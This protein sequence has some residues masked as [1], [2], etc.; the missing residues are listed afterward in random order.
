MI[1]A[2]NVVC[3]D[4]KKNSKIDKSLKR[5]MR[6]ENV[7]GAL[8]CGILRHVSV[9]SD[10]ILGNNYT[11]SYRSN[12]LEAVG[13]MLKKIPLFGRIIIGVKD[14]RVSRDPSELAKFNRE[15]VEM[16]D[17]MDLSEPIITEP[18][19][20]QYIP[21]SMLVLEDISRV[22]KSKLL[23]K[24]YF[25]VV[26]EGYS[27]ISGGEIEQIKKTMENDMYRWKKE[28]TKDIRGELGFRTHLPIVHANYFVFDKIQ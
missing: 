3:T 14:V 25:V 15:L 2:V 27:Q 12:I 13:F 22:Y 7:K 24:E 28:T 9:P 20:T 17:D 26:P 8:C 10:A 1:E 11:D 5:R 23:L 6:K 18:V 16:M 19:V 4:Q 21:L